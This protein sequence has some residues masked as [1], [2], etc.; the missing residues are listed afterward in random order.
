M[1]KNDPQNSELEKICK[2]SDYNAIG[3]A[4]ADHNVTKAMLKKLVLESIPVKQRMTINILT[5]S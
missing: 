5:S 2:D 3:C 4:F 1:K